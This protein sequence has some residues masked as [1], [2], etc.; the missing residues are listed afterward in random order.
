[1]YF[2]NFGDRNLCFSSY[3]PRNFR[4]FH[5]TKQAKNKEKI[6][7]ATSGIEKAP[8]VEREVSGSYACSHAV[9]F[10]WRSMESFTK[11]SWSGGN[12][13]FL[14]SFPTM[15]VFKCFLSFI[16]LLLYLRSIIAILFHEIR[17]YFSI[18]SRTCCT[19]GNI[20]NDSRILT[21]LPRHISFVVLES[22]ISFVDL[23]QLIVWSMAMGI[24]YVSVYDREGKLP[25]ISTCMMQLIYLL[26]NLNY[27]V[28][29]FCT[30]LQTD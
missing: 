20:R 15:W 27:K 14:S 8:E 19:H 25:T 13:E 30:R 26:S 29:H 4:N 18:S 16:H 23:A 10:Q 28:V 17:S 11:W 9:T 7:H 22:D 21:K 5:L 2:I 3:A 12:V 24:P 6:C 1:M